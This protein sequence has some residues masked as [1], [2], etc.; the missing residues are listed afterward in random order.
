M[1]ILD[2][3]KTKRVSV[4]TDCWVDTVNNVA[5]FPL[6]NQFGIQKG[7]LVYS[8]NLPKTGHK[9]CKCKYKCK[10]AVF[11]TGNL[12]W[13]LDSTPRDARVVYVT[14]GIFR[15]TALRSVGL[16]AISILGSAVSDAILDQINLSSRTLIWIG[17]PDNAGANLV[18]K[19]KCG[20]L[21]SPQ[22]VDDMSD[23]DLLIFKDYLISKYGC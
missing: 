12:F 2:I 13:G 20:G 11:G 3:L 17:D 4:E 22:D 1:K 21:Q 10:Y 19:F 6:S 14:E 7:Y 15:A 8:P 5:S 18:D 9:K 16:N 23:K